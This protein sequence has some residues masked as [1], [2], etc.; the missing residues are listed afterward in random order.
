VRI[1]LVCPDVAGIDAI[2]EVRQ[3]QAW[4]DVA[5][6]HGTVT[7]TDVYRSLQ[8]KVYDSIYFASHGGSDGILLS[9]N[10]IMSAEDIAQAAR[11]RE[12]RGVFFAACATGRLA[13][14][15][16]RHGMT[17]AI[18]S[19]VDL[20][21]ATAWKLAA[22][23]YGHQR[24]GHAKDFVGAYVL[25]DGG[26]GEYALHI[27][28]TWVQDLQR[29]AVMSAASPHNSLPLTQA[30]LIRWGLFFVAASVAL[31]TLLARLAGG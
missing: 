16:V 14:Y 20:P 28:P 24:N 8:E 26:D 30:E 2:A 19:E 13:S 3:L 4:H 15:C 23:F 17:W 25:A 7:V 18:S 21:D 31:S 9:N 10:V 22:A 1:L 12:V 27:S 11:Q 29:T 5:I 6:L